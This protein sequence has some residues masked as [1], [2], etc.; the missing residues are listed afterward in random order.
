MLELTEVMLFSLMILLFVVVSLL[1]ILQLYEM[2]NLFYEK[3]KA[4]PE[5]EQD[6]QTRQSLAKPWENKC[7]QVVSR[8][9]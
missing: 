4:R 9:T 8:V 6:S 7:D 3:C 1:C 2:N 5:C